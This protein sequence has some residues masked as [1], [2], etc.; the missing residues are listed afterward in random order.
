MQQLGLSAADFKQY[1]TH[2]R[3]ASIGVTIQARLLDLA[4]GLREQMFGVI[5]GTINVD[6]TQAGQP[7]R[8]ATLIL[9]DPNHSMAWDSDSPGLGAATINN[10][11]RLEHVTYVPALGRRVVCPLMTGPVSADKGFTRSGSQVTL[12]VDG[13]ETLMLGQ[14]FRT[15]SYGKGS[16]R[17]DALKD[18]L[19]FYG[20]SPTGLIPDL[21]ARL[22]APLSIGRTT[23]PW[24]AAQQLARGLNR[25]LYF[26][27][28]GQA[29]LRPIPGH[30]THIVR[31]GDNGPYFSDVLGEVQV[32]WGLTSG[33][34]NVVE[35]I[36]ATANTRAIAYPPTSHMLHPQNMGA[37][38]AWNV[39]LHTET[40]NTVR[41]VPEAQARANTLMNEMLMTSAQVTAITKCFP[42]LEE[43]DVVRFQLSSGDTNQRLSK[44]SI[45]LAGTGMSLGYGHQ[46]HKLATP[47]VTKPPAPKKRHR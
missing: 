24:E 44:M 7:V 11:I 36:G 38:G 43:D 6:T 10:Q 15:K 19:W 9:S 20:G 8:S 17:T 39:R 40:N 46:F 4:G 32:N 14:A 2:L 22:P 42:F 13:R 28:A 37:N 29:V 1:V 23:V 25:Q 35:V 3:S 21:P 5:G 31:E 27:A 18:I 26:N 47:R 16:K 12:N 45:D 33:W 34:Y 41:T 30:A